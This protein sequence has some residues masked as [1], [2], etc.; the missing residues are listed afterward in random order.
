MPNSPAQRSIIDLAQNAIG[1]TQSI[2]LPAAL[3]RFGRGSVIEVF[4]FG[5]EGAVVNLVQ[6]I[7][8]RLLGRGFVMGR[9]ASVP[10]RIRS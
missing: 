9:T 8:E 2:D 3:R 5:F 10:K 6:L 7:S 4:V 1:E